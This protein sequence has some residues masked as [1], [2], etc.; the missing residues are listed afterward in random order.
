MP[1]RRLR[2]PRLGIAVLFGLL[3]TFGAQGP[4]LAGGEQIRL[5]LLPVGQRGSF[6]DLV[7]LPGDSRT[8]AVDISND[9]AAALAARTY[10]ADVYTIINGGFGGRLH[11][12]P[13]TGT[14]RLTPS[15]SR[16]ANAS[17]GRSRWSSRRT[18]LRGS[19]SPA[20]SSNTTSRSV[21]AGLS[22]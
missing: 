12:E 3:V 19:T 11:D 20:S 8:L 21:A 9:G 2:A 15:S 17:V 4:A 14:T 6:F 22:V 1:S 5:A 18:P 7:M 10:A 16:P 13:E